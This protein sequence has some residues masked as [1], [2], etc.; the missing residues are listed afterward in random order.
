VRG[1]HCWWSQE[2]LGC[3]GLIVLCGCSG[4]PRYQEPLRL[5]PPFNFA[6]PVHVEETDRGVTMVISLHIV[7]CSL[8]LLLLLPPFPALLPVPLKTHS[9][10]R[11]TGSSR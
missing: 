2:E 5:L 11:R 9:L 6:T 4:F 8:L 3:A 1:A 10:R 7:C